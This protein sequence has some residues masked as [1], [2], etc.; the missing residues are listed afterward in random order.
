MFERQSQLPEGRLVACSHHDENRIETV[1]K[2]TSIREFGHPET[3]LELEKPRRMVLL[4]VLPSGLPLGILNCRLGFRGCIHVRLT[5]R[6][7]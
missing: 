7:C 4:V 6:L 2:K 1:W 5:D 3:A